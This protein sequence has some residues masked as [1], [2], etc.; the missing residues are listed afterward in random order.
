MIGQTLSHYRIIEKIGAQEVCLICDLD[1]SG[2]IERYVKAES[3]WCFSPSMP[4]KRIVNHDEIGRGNGL[5]ASH[6][7]SKCS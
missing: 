7:L 1:L 5:S 6:L 2:M 3:G 4:G